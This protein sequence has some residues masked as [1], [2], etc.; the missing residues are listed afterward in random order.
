MNLKSKK[1]LSLFLVFS[2]VVLSGNLYAKKRGAELTIIKKDGHLIR[3]ELIAVKE[4]S[5]L[6]LSATDISI[7]I[8]DIK[9]IEI[10][11]KSK[12]GKGALYGLLIC[13]G[14]GALLGGIAGAVEEEHDVSIL[15]GA[16]IGTLFFAP[17]GAL[18]GAIIG[19]VATG[20]DET[21]QIEGMSDL[22]I[23][24]ALNKL[25]KKARIRNFQ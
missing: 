13:G 12:L 3:G 6:L 20:A 9:V 25:R 24:E 10:E 7:D 4:H 14:G 5:L 17:A 8:G 15:G 11:K 22:E 16:L 1:L 23:R 18:L 19:L 21:I 2:L